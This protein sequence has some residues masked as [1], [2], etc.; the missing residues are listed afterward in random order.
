[1]KQLLAVALALISS[2]SYAVEFKFDV[3]ALANSSTGGTGLNTG[4]FFNA[5]D[6]LNV[7]VD[8][9]DIWS[10]GALPR[11]SNANGLVADL[12]ATG[13]DESGQPAGTQIGTTF[14]S[15][16]SN[17]LTAPFGTLVGSL[18][19]TFFEL[20]TEYAGTAPDSGELLLYY[21]DSNAADNADFVTVTVDD[22]T[23]PAAGEVPA[24][25]ILALFGLGAI[26]MA[27]QRRR[28][29]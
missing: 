10:A 13:L 21:W 26:G 28:A 7:S 20:G 1:M 8:P 16:T 6:S 15:Y 3:Y 14:S 27:W 12:L 19:P 4:L 29:G 17:G 11:W 9:N 18:G 25:G 2:A 23:T 22:G 24:P 5:G